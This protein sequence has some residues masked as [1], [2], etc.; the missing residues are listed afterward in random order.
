MWKY[1]GWFGLDLFPDCE[2]PVE[3]VQ[4]KINNLKYLY[5]LLERV[6]RE[7]CRAAMH[8]SDAVKIFKL[9]RRILGGLA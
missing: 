3:V 7:E 1:D 9:K 4:E 2:G 6:D 8:T 5:E